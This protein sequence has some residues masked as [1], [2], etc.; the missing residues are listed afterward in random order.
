MNKAMK[1]ALLSAFVFP[2]SGQFYLKRYWRGLLMMMLIVLGLTVI[3][4]RATIGALDALK[5]MQGNGTSVDFNAI[6]HL[7][8]TTSAN[9]YTDNTIILV[10]LVVCWI[11]SVVDAYKIGKR[12]I[13][14]VG[15]GQKTGN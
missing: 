8:E 11:F 9:I 6:S 4:A 13:P 7:T 12:S 3:I 15:D 5:V 14:N 10:F 2:G 1:A